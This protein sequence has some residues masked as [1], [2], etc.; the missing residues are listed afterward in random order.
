MSARTTRIIAL[1]ALA[2]AI[3]LFVWRVRDILS[4][5]IA[6]LVIAY[7]LAPLVG[8]LTRRRLS[9]SLAIALVYLMLFALIG[10]FLFYLIPGLVVELTRLAQNLPGYTEQA[11]GLITQLQQRY[12]LESMPDQ[13]RQVIINAVTTVGTRLLTAVQRS[14]EGVVNVVSALVKV[15]LS[16]I[17]SVYF[18]NDWEAIGRAL[19]GLMPARLRPV[20]LAAAA[21]LDRMLGSYIRSMIIVATIIGLLSGV[22]T[23]L[24]G[25]RFALLFGLIAGIMEFIPYFGPV[26]A[27]VPPIILALF[28]SPTLALKV[29]ITYVVIQQLESTIIS[30]KIVGEHVG[31]RPV[32]IVFALLAGQ[33][34]AGIPGMLLAVPVAGS[35]KI[36]GSHCGRYLMERGPEPEPDDGRSATTTLDD[37]PPDAESDEI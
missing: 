7:L 21:D 20:I 6:G 18:L 26:L 9:R 37:A 17:L 22:A 12:Q 16:L 3:A 25:L 11:Q 19:Q 27:A 10:T 1:A 34:L 5:F 28:T 31:V 2:A 13:V 29:A 4:P 23:G 14:L 36:I 35:L 32:T 8:T 15:G 24:W 33:A 30:P